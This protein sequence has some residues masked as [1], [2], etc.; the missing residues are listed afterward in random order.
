MGRGGARVEQRNFEVSAIALAALAT[1]FQ[2][3]SEVHQMVAKTF[4][5]F[6]QMLNP[7]FD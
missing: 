6:N 1:A 2:A 4:S 7:A 5:R 3:C